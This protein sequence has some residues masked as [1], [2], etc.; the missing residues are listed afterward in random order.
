MEHFFSDMLATSWQDVHKKFNLRI[1]AMQI[2]I[3]NSLSPA[4]RTYIKRSIYAQI[5]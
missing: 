3:Y 1:I 2:S 4:H 5:A